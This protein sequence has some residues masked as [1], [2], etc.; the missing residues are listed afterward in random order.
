[1]GIHRRKTGRGAII[2]AI[3]APIWRSVIILECR[4]FVGW[5]VD[6]A[7]RIAGIPKSD[8]Y[9]HYLAY[10]EV[11][12][13]SAWYV[14]VKRCYWCR[15]ELTSS[16]KL[17]IVNCLDVAISSTVDHGTRL[18]EITNEA[19][20]K[21]RSGASTNRLRYGKDLKI[22][23]TRISVAIGAVKVL[24]PETCEDN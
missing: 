22:W 11:L 7:H 1:M 21:K 10:H 4:R 5:Y 24:A 23:L 17:T 14:Y 15:C 16:R 8:A 20:L 9:R 13:A 19:R 12:V 2:V 6:R 18:T 3:P